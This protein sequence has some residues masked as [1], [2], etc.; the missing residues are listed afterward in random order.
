MRQV[1]LEYLDQNDAFAACLPRN[2]VVVG[3]FNATSDAGRWHLIRLDI[4]VSYQLLTGRGAARLVETEYV[5]V[6]SRWAG[7]DVGAAEATSVFILLVEP[8]QLPL[9]SPVDPERYHHVA[10]GMCTTVDAAQQGD[11]ADEA[12]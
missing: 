7:Q 10:W 9:S 1:R 5:L 8:S 6:R 4:P 2:G 11:E 3:R 12:R